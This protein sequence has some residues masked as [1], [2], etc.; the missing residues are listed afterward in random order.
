MKNQLVSPAT[1]AFG[2]S[3]AGCSVI[4]ALL[5]IAKEKSPALQAI[6][7]SLTGHHWITHVVFVVGLFLGT[8][9]LFAGLA[10]RGEG[11]MPVDRLITVI[12]SGVGVAGLLIIGFY[13]IGD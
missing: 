8:G 10:K 4:N 9:A 2:L 13:L 3:L 5:V 7:K 6:M 1:I 11:Q 12:V